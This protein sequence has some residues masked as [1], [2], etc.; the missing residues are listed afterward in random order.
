MRISVLLGLSDL[1]KEEVKETSPGSYRGRVAG[2]GLPAATL[3]GLGHQRGPARS[4]SR[5]QRD[6]HVTT[7]ERVWPLR[8][9][10]PGCSQARRE[11]RPHGLSPHRPHRASFRAVPGTCEPGFA[12]TAL[13]AA[14]YL[15][16]CQGG[17]VSSLKPGQCQSVCAGDRDAGEKATGH[18]AHASQSAHYSVKGTRLRPSPREQASR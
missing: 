3:T 1:T 8:T 17:P 4:A 16:G 18:R 15:T 5:L 11:P 13:G 9:P 7:R 6:A 2:L 10:R 14:S 12:A